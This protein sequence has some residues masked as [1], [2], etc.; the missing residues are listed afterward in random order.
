MERV[1]RSTVG[2]HNNATLM[3]P[4][5]KPLPIVFER[6]GK[7][8]ANSRDVAAF[9]E[10][11][12]DNVLADVRQITEEQPAFAALNFQDCPYRGGNGKTLP[13]YDM[14]KD[15]FTFLVMGYTGQKAST[16]KLRYI[17]QFNAME[18]ALASW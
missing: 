8:H 18:A 13:S 3:P 14:T 16:F 4:D 1:V 6:G 5:D 17:E 15:G 11:R 9:F 7:V 12:H 2:A 10:K